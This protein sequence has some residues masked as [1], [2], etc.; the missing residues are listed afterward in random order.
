MKSLKKSA[1]PTAKQDAPKRKLR[2]VKCVNESARS[3]SFDTTIG[4]LDLS[5]WQPFPG[6][7]W[8]QTRLPELARKLAQR[9]DSRLVMWGVAGGYLRTFEFRHGLAWARRLIRRY[10]EDLKTTNEQK[11]DSL[12]PITRSHPGKGSQRGL[13]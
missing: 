8:I 9:S 6:A 1:R 2:E 12:R 3:I 10:T 4:Y 13:T 7:T 5:A 11:I